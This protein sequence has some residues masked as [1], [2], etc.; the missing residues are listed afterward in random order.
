MAEYLCDLGIIIINVGEMASIAIDS[1]EEA[2]DLFTRIKDIQNPK[3]QNTLIYLG[4][5]YRTT[6]DYDKEIDCIERCI[7]IRNE[8]GISS[9]VW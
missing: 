3:L 6:G 5:V 8:L 2:Y 9:R 1:L 4:I 7:E